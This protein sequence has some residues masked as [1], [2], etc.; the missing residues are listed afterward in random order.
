MLFT[1]GMMFVPVKLHVPA[2]ELPSAPVTLPPV[3]SEPVS[4][5]SGLY[6]RSATV[7][8]VTTIGVAL[9]TVMAAVPVSS[10]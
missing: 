7:G 10:A 2:S 3:I 8:T 9:A 4:A 5:A 6:Q 1:V